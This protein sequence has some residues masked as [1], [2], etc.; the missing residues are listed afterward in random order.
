MCRWYIPTNLRIYVPTSNHTSRLGKLPHERV[1]GIVGV[2][3]SQFHRLHFAWA[4]VGL[5]VAKEDFNAIVEVDEGRK[6]VEGHVTEVDAR[7]L[8]K[9][10]F[11][12]E[13]WP[14]L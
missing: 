4:F 1:S 5:D 7:K 12:F 11:L 9:A 6:L 3:D 13:L 2:L 14:I 10:K 8:K